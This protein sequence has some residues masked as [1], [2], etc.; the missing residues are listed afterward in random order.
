MKV[1]VLSVPEKPKPKKNTYIAICQS[2]ESICSEFIRQQLKI[3]MA[4]AHITMYFAS[5]F[6]MRRASETELKNHAADVPIK[7][8][9]A[10]VAL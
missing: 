10:T 4:Q 8:S 1:S 5:N 6:C 7:D 3:K 9:P 2:G